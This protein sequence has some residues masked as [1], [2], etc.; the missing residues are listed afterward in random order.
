MKPSQ[1]LG[2][3]IFAHSPRNPLNQFLAVGLHPPCL[4]F[5]LL[6]VHD[7]HRNLFTCFS[8]AHLE[9][10]QNQT[11]IFDNH[12][13]TLCSRVSI[14]TTRQRTCLSAFVGMLDFSSREDPAVREHETCQTDN[15]K[16]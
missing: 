3:P 5:C 14:M 6:V 7:I 15:Q 10:L 8:I 4:A 12:S 1:R 16:K 9:D 13:T 2:G 11:I